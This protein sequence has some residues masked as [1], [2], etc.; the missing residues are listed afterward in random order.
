MKLINWIINILYQSTIKYGKEYEKNKE[1][2]FIEKV[3][4][5]HKFNK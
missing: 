3:M 2:A 5:N 1:D 4:A